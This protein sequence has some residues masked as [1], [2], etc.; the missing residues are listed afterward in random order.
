MIMQPYTNAGLPQHGP[1]LNPIEYTAVG[2][3]HD[4]TIFR[5]SFKQGQVHTSYGAVRD[6][7]TTPDIGG[8]GYIIEEDEW[9]ADYW[10]PNMEEGWHE[11]MTYTEAEIQAE[12]ADQ[13]FRYSL[14]TRN[15]TEDWGGWLA[16]AGGVLAPQFLDPVNY[17]PLAGIFTKAARIGLKF[18][19][20]SKVAYGL[21][22]AL[23]ET[24]RQGLFFARDEAV[25]RNF[26]AATGI[27]SI[28]IGMGIG[29]GYGTLRDLHKTIPFRQRLQNLGKAWDDL[30]NEK[31]LSNLNNDPYV[32]QAPATRP[33]TT[34]EVDAGVQGTR[35]GDET[36]FKNEATPED[37]ERYAALAP[38][39]IRVI[40]TVK[41][42]LSRFGG[43]T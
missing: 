8:E 14:I 3:P 43:R 23:I 36:T 13:E 11:R 32:T 26:D 40:R 15:A 29:T 34:D 39:R 16:Q 33:L 7:F 17:L 4:T 18:T 19:T 6:L 38:W 22:G 28:A 21:E 5:E 20:S 30:H 1:L 41:Q 2:R 12:R 35:T 42:C 10:R 9:K 37:I 27:F 25:G 31:P 24:G